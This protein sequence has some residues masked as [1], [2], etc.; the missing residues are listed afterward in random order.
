[1]KYDYTAEFMQAILRNIGN[2]LLLPEYRTNEDHNTVAYLYK[3]L[4]ALNFEKPT[5]TELWSYLKLVETLHPVAPE[6]RQAVQTAHDDLHYLI[7]L[8]G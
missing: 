4:K 6:G 8:R 2:L 7:F 1:M 5:E 3:K